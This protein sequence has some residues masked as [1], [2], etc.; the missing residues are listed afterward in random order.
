MALVE[1]SPKE[2]EMNTGLLP[3][4]LYLVPVNLVP[5]VMDWRCNQKT[6]RGVGG[7]PNREHSSQGET[8]I[9]PE[10]VVLTSE[11]AKGRK[12]G[13]EGEE[14]RKAKG[15]EGVGERKERGRGGDK[16]PR[17]KPVRLLS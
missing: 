7:D 4:A 3:L 17:G 5:V 10:D 9:H 1:G 14:R 15:E 2:R 13:E 16:T 8:E 12:E 6:V 11:T